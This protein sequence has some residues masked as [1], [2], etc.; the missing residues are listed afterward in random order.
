[1]ICND[2][3]G[4]GHP[5]GAPSDVCFN[6]QGSGAVCNSCDQPIQDGDDRYCDKCINEMCEGDD[7]DT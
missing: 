5:K 3:G 1:M 6:C 2:C 7:D 4:S